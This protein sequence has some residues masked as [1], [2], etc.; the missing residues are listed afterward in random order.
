MG[1]DIKLLTKEL[2]YVIK[3]SYKKKIILRVEPVVT[4][5]R[6]VFFQ[7][8]T[9]KPVLSHTSLYGTTRSSSILNHK[10]KTNHT[11]N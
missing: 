4:V 11:T 8:E 10:I 9:I 1:S 7:Y 3:H 6:E 5:Q 2:S